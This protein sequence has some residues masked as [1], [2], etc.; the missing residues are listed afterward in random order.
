LAS[1]RVYGEHALCNYYLGRL[2]YQKGDTIDAKR[3]FSR[4]RDLDALRAR[5]PGRMDTIIKALCHHH[6]FAHL[7]D[8]KAAFDSCSP[9][10]ITGN[11]LMTG[12]IRPNVKGYTLLSEVFYRAMRQACPSTSP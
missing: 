8:T 6:P 5:A 11:E 4:A 9:G 1:N 3:F 12:F 7:V 2:A 10:H